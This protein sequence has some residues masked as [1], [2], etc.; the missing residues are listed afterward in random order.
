MKNFAIIGKKLG[1]SLSPIIHRYLQEKENIEGSYIRLEIDEI[2]T[3]SIVSS[4]LSLGFK[5][6]NVTIPYKKTV[7]PY[8]DKL[9]PE[10]QKI[11]AVNTILLEND[12]SI[13]FNTDYTG[14]NA[15]LLRA[16]ID[17]AGKDAV[18][19]G[20]GGAAYAVAA[21]LLDRGVRNLTFASRSSQPDI[22]GCAVVPYSAL[23]QAHIVVNSTP[24][25]MAPSVEAS[26]LS[27]QQIG[28][29]ETAIDVIYNPKT[30]LFLQYAQEAGLKSAGGLEMLVG[31]AVESHRIWHNSAVKAGVFEELMELCQK[32]L[33]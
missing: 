10:A 17:C 9:S 11:G 1:H 3:S 22:F 28:L 2:K 4:L 24:L 7:I 12:Q 13:G 16:N 27:K 19:L 29:F 18:I 15:L 23:K 26:P 21:C 14:F 6:A 8:L 33:I 20:T 25:G 30:T 5:G 32:A 31:Q